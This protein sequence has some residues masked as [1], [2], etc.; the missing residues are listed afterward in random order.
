MS[1]A[2]CQFALGLFANIRPLNGV[3]S[4]E[5]RKAKQTDFK[6]YAEELEIN[7]HHPYI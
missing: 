2:D 3:R 4:F 5:H 1:S 7:L 6:K